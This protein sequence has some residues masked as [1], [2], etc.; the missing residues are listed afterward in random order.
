MNLTDI[1]WA[2][3][4]CSSFLAIVFLQSGID[5]I[6][7]HKKELGW[8]QQKFAKNALYNYVGLLFYV[9][10]ISELISGVLSFGGMIH[11]LTSKGPY[12]AQLGAWCSSMTLLMLIFGQRITKDYSGAATLVPYF[13]VSL[14]GLFSLTYQ[15]NL[16]GN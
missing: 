8:I 1:N 15:F 2:G 12:I 16:L 9:L 10:T 5:K 13:I 4:F 3:F 11:L 6:V 14:I 7:N